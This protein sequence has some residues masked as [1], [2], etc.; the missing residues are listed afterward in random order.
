MLEKNYNEIV[1]FVVAASAVE[2][3]ELFRRLPA[4]VRSDIEQAL[5]QEDFVLRYDTRSK[6]AFYLSRHGPGVMMWSWNRVLSHEEAA[7]LLTHLIDLDEP[8][9]ESFANQVYVRATGRRA[10]SRE[11]GD[12]Q[13][14]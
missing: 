1:R 12:T 2:A 4:G 6:R 3:H 7:A 9:N 11:Y 14:G 13:P 5:Q 8:L 10:T